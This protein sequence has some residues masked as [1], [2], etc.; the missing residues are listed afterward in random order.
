VL[1]YV[2]AHSRSTINPEPS[3]RGPRSARSTPLSA[4][5]R[6]RQSG[7][8][9]I[10]RTRGEMHLRAAATTSQG[11][12]NNRGSRRGMRDG[13]RSR[14]QVSRTFPRCM[15]IPHRPRARGPCV[16]ARAR[17]DAT[18]MPEDGDA[19]AAYTYTR[20]ATCIVP[21]HWLNPPRRPF[22]VLERAQINFLLCFGKVSALPVGS[23]PAPV[24]WI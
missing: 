8:R 17:L 22:Y 19:A 13:A 18:R 20:R 6:V 14:K 23:L 5:Q 4:P 7:R 21:Q 10:V 16:R 11:S 3:R 12:L 2:L 15:A 24:R 1:A 9:T